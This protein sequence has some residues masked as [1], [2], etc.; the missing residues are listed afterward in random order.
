MHP[1]QVVQN[2]LWREHS[3]L[4][5]AVNTFIQS[6]LWTFQAELRY[7]FDFCIHRVHSMTVLFHQHF[8]WVNTFCFLSRRPSLRCQEIMFQSITK[9]DKQS[10]LAQCW[11]IGNLQ[12]SEL[13]GVQNRILRNL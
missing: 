7:Y 2:V 13:D 12:F 4:W 10:R 3:S 9:A 1:S 5:G 11:A 8:L 6:P